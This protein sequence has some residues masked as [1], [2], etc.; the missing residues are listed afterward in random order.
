MISRCTFHANL[1]GPAG[2]GGAPGSGGAAHAGTVKDSIVWDCGPIPLGTSMVVDYSNV[3]G[4][5][6]GA[7]GNNIDGDPLFTDV[8]SDDFTLLGGSPSIDAGDPTSPPD[9]DGSRADQGA[10][11]YA[12]T[13]IGTVYCTSVANSTGSVA[14][15]RAL[16]ETLLAAD[17]LKLESDDLPP[18]QYGFFLAAP[19]EGFV[20]NL[21]GGMGTLCLGAPI[22]RLL[23]PPAGQILFSGSSGEF[24]LRSSMLALP[25]GVRPK[26]GE[27]WHFQGWFRD[28]VLGNFTNNTTDAIRFTYN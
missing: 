1:A 9:R 22:T 13:S 12:W 20:P 8:A 19:A 7:G 24:R 16:G 18:N 6:T 26:V 25:I 11:P 23:I 21:G 14:T 27:T 10:F 3:E 5:W 4:G 15:I 28:N 2:G 17:M